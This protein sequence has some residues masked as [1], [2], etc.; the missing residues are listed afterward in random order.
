LIASKRIV[1]FI[2]GRS[3]AG[4]LA[5]AA[6][7]SCERICWFAAGVIVAKCLG[8]QGG[9][10]EPLMTSLGASALL[11]FALLQ[12]PMAQSCAFAAGNLIYFD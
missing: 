2:W 8:E 6:T 3:T 11:V 9:I 7:L 4:G 12:S 10:S 1:P 5:R